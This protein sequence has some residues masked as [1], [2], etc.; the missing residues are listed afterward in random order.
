MAK[1]IAWNSQEADFWASQFAAGQ[2]IELDGLTTHYLERGKP[3]TEHPPIIL[4][5]G[6][7]YDA[8]MW[9]L[10]IDYLA[11]FTQVFALDLW[12]FGYSTR[13]KLD[14]DY[15]FYVEQVKHF[16]Q[17]LSLTNAVL[18]GHSL[19]AGVALNFAC[20]HP[21]RV[22]R[23]ILC[24]AFGLPN[25]SPIANRFFA[26]PVLGSLLLNFSSNWLRKKV[27]NSHLFQDIDNMG[28]AFFNTVTWSQ[29][30]AGSSAVVQQIE[31]RGFFDS[32]SDEIHHLEELDIPVSLIWGRQDRVV[33][34]TRGEHMKRVIPGAEL[35]ILE[36]AGHLS[37]IDQAEQFNQAI[38]E[39]AKLELPSASSSEPSSLAAET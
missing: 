6:Y 17:T 29:K 18:V 5:H 35:R 32:L 38:V 24:D 15:P 16:M 27:I 8:S 4:L 1:F 7:G 33:P 26:L 9:S 28:S 11:Q 30:I 13:G 3:R 12:G 2:R 19:G 31:K 34:F 23:L 20:E 36:D 21:E 25:A 22:N 39:F 37:N 10:N 14:Y